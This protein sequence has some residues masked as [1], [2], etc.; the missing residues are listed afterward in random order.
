MPT[1]EAKKNLFEIN[2]KGVN[3]SPNVNF[4]NLIRETKG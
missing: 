2:F 4:D 1:E 3:W